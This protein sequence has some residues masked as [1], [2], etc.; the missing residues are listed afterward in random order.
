MASTRDKVGETRTRWALLIGINYYRTSPL[1]GAVLDVEILHDHLKRILTPTNIITLTASEPRTPGSSIPNEDPKSWPTYD[2]IIWN[3]QRVLRDGKAGDLVFIHFSGHGSSVS[4]GTEATTRQPGSL[5]LVVLSNSGDVQY[6]HG[7]VFATLLRDMVKRGMLV[8]VVLDCCFSGGVQRVSHASIRSIPYDPITA[9]K[10]G[11]QTESFSESVTKATT[12]DGRLVPKW[13]IEP[14]GYTILAACGPH[15]TTKELTHQDGT[16]NGILTFFLT[17]ALNSLWR[18]GVQIT[19]RSLYEL[20]RIQFHVHNPS[21]TPMRYGNKNFAFFGSPLLDE[22]TL[23]YH[24]FKSEQNDSIRMAGGRVNGI[25]IGDVLAVYPLYSCEDTRTIHDASPWIKA[26]VI[27]VH[28]LSSDIRLDQPAIKIASL[29]KGAIGKARP[30]KSVSSEKIQIRILQEVPDPYH[31]MQACH[32]GRHFELRLSPLADNQPCLFHL[33]HK[34][35]NGYIILDENLAR[36]PSLP[37][38]HLS[39]GSPTN[40]LDETLEHISAFKFFEQLENRSYTTWWKRS[41]EI[42]IFD[43]SAATATSDDVSTLHVSA[44]ASISLRIANVGDSPIYCAIFNLGPSWQIDNVLSEDGGSEFLAIPSH[45]GEDSV[46]EISICTSVP[47]A[48]TQQGIRVCDD[49]LKVFVTS[50]PINFGP[51]LLPKIAVEGQACLGLPFRGTR[52]FMDRF[53]AEISGSTRGEAH[54]HE[55]FSQNFMVRTTLLEG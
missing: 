41:F 22:Q 31:L 24:V 16:Q 40:L 2:N 18:R 17:F 5:A 21:Q 50:T 6:L 54:G 27:A 28:A 49:V 15:E 45:A 55:W 36:I 11:D 8:T 53:I 39:N 47:E 7:D 51:M 20:L 48:L 30:I 43:E 42:R 46:E 26:E 4:S 37:P 9:A 14:D 25:S 1:K 29:S 10:Y 38:F 32:T 52:N 13:L 12:R 19:H 23:F 3:V 35:D 33:D 44:G 34:S